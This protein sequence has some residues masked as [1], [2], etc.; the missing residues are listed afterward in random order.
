MKRHLNLWIWAFLGLPA[1]RLPADDYQ[2][3]IRPLLASYCFDCHGD[4]ADPEGGR[5]LERFQTMAQVMAE[6]ADWAVVQDKVE[7]GQ[8]PPPKKKSQPTEAERQ[9]ILAW[10]SSLA[11]APDPVLGQRDPGK[12]VLRRLTRL[13][14]NNT[15]RDLF[16]LKMDVFMFPERLPLNRDYFPDSLSPSNQSKIPG[17]LQEFPVPPS[18]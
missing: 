16:G 17:N 8:M 14:Y 9:Q 1:A 7:S 11:A 13:E 5:N 10:I 4:E 6:R 18:P 12:P 3:K 15:V 2:E